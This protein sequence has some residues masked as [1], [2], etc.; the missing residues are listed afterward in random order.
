MFLD[1][2]L[3]LFLLEILGLVL[4]QVKTKLSATAERRV[5][6]IRGDG[7][8]AT[9]SGLP[10]ILLVVIV[11]GD[12]LDALCDE[13]SRVETNTELT[14]HGNIGTRAQCLHEPL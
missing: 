8:G 14:D 5:D 2:V 1:N 11:F 9:G 10:D 13:V 3:D 7:E 12:D 4:F 6:G